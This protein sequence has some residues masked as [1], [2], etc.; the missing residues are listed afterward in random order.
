MSSRF[1]TG[2]R[3][4]KSGV[5]AARKSL[6]QAFEHGHARVRD[7]VDASGRRADGSLDLVEKTVNSLVDTI[8]QRG[9]GYAKAGRNRLSQAQAQLLPRRRSPPIGTALVAVG[10]GV[11]LSLLFR[12]RTGPKV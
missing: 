8:A 1:E 3:V 2:S 5:R 7:V 9:R 4:A 11:L 12:T 10:A 6:S